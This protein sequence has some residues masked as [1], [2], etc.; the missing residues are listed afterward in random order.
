MQYYKVFGQKFSLYQEGSSLFTYLYTWRVVG[1]APAKGIF[2]SVF[3]WESCHYFFS[4]ED[5]CWSRF[6]LNILILWDSLIVVGNWFQS[7]MTLRVKKLLLMVVLVLCLVSLV[8]SCDSLVVLT[9]TWLTLLNQT[10][11]PSTSR[12]FVGFY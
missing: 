10:S 7:L 5:K 2:F 1:V 12:V 9:D 6:L 11:S 8:L 4:E 3:F